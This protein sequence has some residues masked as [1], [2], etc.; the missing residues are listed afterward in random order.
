MNGFLLGREYFLL[1]AIRRVT[2]PAAEAMWR[3]YF[4]RIWIAG[5]AIAVP[6]SVPILNL[7]VPMIG[8]AVFT[9]QFHR[10]KTNT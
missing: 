9:H 1:V 8:V 5:T 10:L 7:V 3:R 4:W 2:R 6:L